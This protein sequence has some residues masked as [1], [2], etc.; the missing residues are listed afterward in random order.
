M[1]STVD[2]LENLEDNTQWISENYDVL[3]QKFNNE[4]VAVLDKAVIDHDSDL[5]RLVNR[6]RKHHSAVYNE[7]AVEYITKEELDLI[8]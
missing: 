8:L 1:E 7:I 4:W 5:K 2:V 3:K 6:L